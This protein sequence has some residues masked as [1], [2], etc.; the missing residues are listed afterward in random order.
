MFGSMADGTPFGGRGAATVGGRLCCGPTS[1][2]LSGTLGGAGVGPGLSTPTGSVGTGEGV[3]SDE[4][5]GSG[6]TIGIGS[7]LLSIV[8]FA[9]SD[10]LTLLVPCGKQGDINSETMTR[11][12]MQ[13]DFASDR[14]ESRVNLFM[15]RLQ[16]RGRFRNAE[17][18]PLALDD[19]SLKRKLQLNNLSGH[20]CGLRESCGCEIFC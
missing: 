16:K 17:G 7:V 20:A 15:V 13:T 6:V 2:G 8:R 4:G 5:V 19:R 11:T 1:G 18:L 14:E 3:G 12:R 9:L 10:A